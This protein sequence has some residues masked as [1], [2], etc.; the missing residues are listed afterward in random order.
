[1]EELNVPKCSLK[2]VNIEKVESIFPMLLIKI[3]MKFWI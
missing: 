1:M 2:V 3:Y